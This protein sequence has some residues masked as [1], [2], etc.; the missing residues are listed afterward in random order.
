MLR[1]TIPPEPAE[2][3]GL[4]TRATPDESEM[5]TANLPSLGRDRAFWGM[6]A[7]QF[8]GAFNDNLYKQLM[9]LLAIPIG[10]AA[11]AGQQDQQDIATI[12]FSLPFVLFSGIAG[13]LADRYRKSRVI[14]LSKVA[15]I[16]VMALG[17]V[18]FLLYSYLG[19]TGLMVVLFLMGAQSTFFGPSKYGILPELFRE[20]DLPRANGI[21]MMTT[22]LAILF[23]TVSAGLLGDNLIDTS[24]P[25]A[26]SASNLWI[27]SALCIAIAVLGTMTALLIRRVTAAEPGLR[28]EIGSW[29]IPRDTRAILARDRPLIG[30]ILASS[31]F[32]MVSGITIQAVNSL[33]MV[34][35][36]R[37]MKQTS[38]MAAMIGLGIAL[39]GVLAG[40][41]SH[42]RANPRV[43]RAGLWGIV[44]MLLL[45]SIS[46]PI[47]DSSRP[48]TV[49]ANEVSSPAGGSEVT[50]EGV[51]VPASPTGNASVADA[52]RRYRHLLGFWGSLPALATLGIAAAM[53]AI[54]LQVFVQSRPPDD[55]K[56]RMIAVMN[57]ANFLAILL[58]GVVYGLFD[59]LVVALG[60]PRSP[61]FAMMA[62]LVV[63]VLL[64]YHP[65]FEMNKEERLTC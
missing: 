4:A 43:A 65:K 36:Q 29:F 13:Y 55:Q 61:I 54:P 1:M 45:I 3:D 48:K 40:R 15:E 35:L 42:G 47:D 10:A 41:L 2:L 8:L 53:F 14:F 23:G 38:I 32:W 50:S 37:N 26:A 44:A 49:T 33:G 20:S 7:T 25:L 30:A 60:W 59:S 12:V 21:I 24:Q 62:V 27:G 19:Y 57:Q 64:L 17:M 22:F 16:V 63:P 28:L 31:V 9:L 52:N 51:D 46:L 5:S 18:A 39:G 58:S 34:Q 56:G 11:V 6:T